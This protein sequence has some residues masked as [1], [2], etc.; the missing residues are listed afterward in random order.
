M[1]RMFSSS[2]LDLLIDERDGERGTGASRRCAPRPAIEPAASWCAGRRSRL[3][4]R[5]PGP[6]GVFWS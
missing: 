5:R 4:S 3:P 1:V 2:H 6:R